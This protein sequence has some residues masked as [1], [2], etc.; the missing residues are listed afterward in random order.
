M[1]VKGGR[2][3]Q[4]IDT[5]THTQTQTQPEADPLP[6][7]CHIMCQCSEVSSEKKHWPTKEGG[8]FNITQTTVGT[9]SWRLSAGASGVAADA[10][11]GAH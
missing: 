3:K 8:L 7:L 1:W 9:G 4:W 6:M 2:V 11:Q 5:L 10:C